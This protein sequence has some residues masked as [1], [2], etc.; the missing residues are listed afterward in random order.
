MVVMLG[1]EERE[2]EQMMNELGLSNKVKSNPLKGV[3]RGGKKEMG[4]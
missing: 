1:W 3:S 4:E 2:K